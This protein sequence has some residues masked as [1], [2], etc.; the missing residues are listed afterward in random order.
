MRG[1]DKT[2][3]KDETKE[4]LII[5]IVE[6]IGGRAWLGIL[7]LTIFLVVV[8]VLYE[9]NV[10]SLFLEKKRLITILESLGNIS[11]IG[12]IIIQALQV[13]VSPI[14]GEVTGF[15]GGYYYGPILGIILSTIGL[16]LGSLLAFSLSRALGKPFVEKTVKK[17]ILERFNYILGLRRKESFL[18]LL[19]FLIPGF[20]KDYLCYVLGL[21][22]MNYKE[23]LLISSL[24]RLLGTIL[25]TFGGSYFRQ[26]RYREFFILIGIAITVLLI[27]IAF[28]NKIESILSRLFHHQN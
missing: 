3:Q 19:L 2:E 15:V 7:T 1:G 13:I 12:F 17:E 10:F 26:Q 5:E 23:F 28:R 20:P 6:T 18:V 27:A 9:S 25:I 4:G 16:T 8:I 11:F 21:G 24:G 14:P 22:S